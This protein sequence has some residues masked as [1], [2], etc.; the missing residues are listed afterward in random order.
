MKKFLLIFIILVITFAENETFGQY[1]TLG[2]G[3]TTNGT[4]S[5][6]PV[7]IYYRRTVCQFVYTA[8]EL[9]TA[10]L[11]GADILTQIGWYVTQV[12]LYS[13]PGYT[14]KMKH[15]TADDVSSSLGTTGWTEVKSA[16]TYM[17][18]VGGYDMITFDQNFVWNG[19]DNIGIELCWAQIQPNFNQSGQCR[20]YSSN[21][22]FR[23]SWTDDAGNSCG[24][25]PATV[26]SNKPQAQ[27]GYNPGLPNDVGVHTLPMGGFYNTGTVVTP[28]ALIKNYGYNPQT[29][30][31][32]AVISDGTSNIYSDTKT[33]TGLAPYNTQ[34]VNF[35]NWT[36]VIGNYTI[37]ITTQ[38]AGDQN[39]S[40]D[41]QSRNFVVDN[42]PVAMTGNISDHH[43]QS[44]NL[45]NGNLFNIGNISSAPFPTAEEYDG[46]Q[47]YRLCGDFTF[48]SV[49][50]DGNFT[51]IGTLTGVT[52]SPTG[53]AWN[54][55]TQTMYVLVLNSSQLPV[56][57]TLNMSTLVLTPVGTG[58]EGRIM[59]IDFADDGFLYGPSINP[60]KLYRID[61][62][63]GAVT[64]IGPVG[65]DLNF[66]QDVSFDL[67]TNQLYT[68]TCGQHSHFGT[69]NLFTG[70]FSMIADLNGKQHATLVI[71]NPAGSGSNN[72]MMVYHA[73]PVP[74]GCNYM[75]NI[76]IS[77]VIKNN[78]Y[79]SQSNVPVSYSI[80]GGT[81]VTAAIQGPI[82]PGEFVNYTF[83]QTADFSSPGNYTVS[84]CTGL[85]GDQYP[86]NDCKN[87]SFTKYAHSTAPYTMGFETD[88]NSNLW[89]IVDVNGGQTWQI[90]E[91]QQ[92]ARTGDWLALYEYSTTL[93]ANDWLFSTCI[94]LEAS[95]TYDLLFWY[96]VG[97]RYGVV[98]PEKLKVM[99]GDEPQPSAM[100]DLIVDLGTISNI[101]YQL[102]ASSFT[103]PSDG[104]YFIGW[105]AYSFP[106]MFYISI[107]DITVDISQN[108]IDPEKNKILLFP[109]PAKE[110]LT[111]ISERHI[112]NLEVFNIFGQRISGFEV[113]AL[114]SSI[115]VSALP[116][117]VY[118]IRIFTDNDIVTK[119]FIVAD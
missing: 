60:D 35:A 110:T 12:P 67:A 70:E 19:I 84:V 59:A 22:G 98:Y 42:F 24:L 65:M 69:Y 92:L 41:S 100:T 64:A 95:K 46:N 61:P 76:P 57:C 90:T 16:F 7:N 51:L 18:V 25:T 9:T 106:D 109:N 44:I 68:I 104:I 23:Y 34:V 87:F 37:T 113:H 101:N 66:G 39:A 119:Q 96:S 105:H 118:M 62:A 86:A 49:T 85:P 10:G 71:S 111:L 31:V 112:V 63:T 26:N 2:T 55:D 50:P 117:G 77:V 108:I 45:S 91:Y 99:I 43:Y 58:T 102:S 114:Q 82:S 81:P 83:S 28:N 89:S 97:K 3:T 13:I 56:L 21:D 79:A 8:A 33:V 48:G 20:I 15:V 116:P 103:V 93:P 80:N 53:L 30:N 73:D 29:F 32:T 94:E 6:S 47:I 107:D 17:P 36:S 52:G 14:I 115:D 72:D 75:N 38:L 54:W 74:S 78:G 1:I 5:C 88:E 4:Q 27:I 11:S 40:N